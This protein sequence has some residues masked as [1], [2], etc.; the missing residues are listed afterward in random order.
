MENP[1]IKNLLKTAKE[2]IKQKEFNEALKI[3]KVS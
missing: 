2:A 1:E 3:C